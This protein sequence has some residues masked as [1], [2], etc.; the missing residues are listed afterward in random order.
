[1]TPEIQKAYEA[2]H[3]ASANYW[4]DYYVN[5]DPEST[6]RHKRHKELENALHA[7]DQL[8]AKQ[9]KF[10]VIT[11]PDNGFGGTA[12]A[13]ERRWFNRTTE[14]LPLVT[15]DLEDAERACAILNEVYNS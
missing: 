10:K 5:H 13:I 8:L 7:L 1:M 4:E 15:H 2:L 6:T 14:T 12:Y 3:I 9:S 11:L